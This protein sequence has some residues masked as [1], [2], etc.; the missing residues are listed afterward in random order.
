MQNRVKRQSS[1]TALIL[2]TGYTARAFIPYLQALG[3]AITT[4]K[5][6]KPVSIEGVKE[7]PFNGTLSEDLR[8]AFETADVILTSIPPFKPSSYPNG[9]EFADP[10]LAALSGLSP[11]PESWIGYLSATSVYG[12]LSGGW[13]TENSPVA[14]SLRRGKARAEAEIA[15]IETGWPVHIFRL[16][17]IYGP[18]FARGRNPFQRL[19][20]GTAR[21][22]IKDGHIVNRIHVE[23]SGWQ[24][25]PA[26]RCLE[27]RS[28]FNWCCAP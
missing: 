23:D 2:G 6:S 24:P 5:R 26:A 4:T 9:T 12:D 3:Y 25:C 27:L 15:W 1:K 8:S 20:A 16:A 28:G 22:V 14:P 17:G 7:I 13:A 18:S 11:K 21:A 19:Q 10:A